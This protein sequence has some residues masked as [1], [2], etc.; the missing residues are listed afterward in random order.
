[1]SSEQTLNAFLDELA[2][3]APAPGGG[4]AAAAAGAMGAALV[5]MVCNLTIG[6]EK[7]AAVENQMKAI[8]A[9]AGELQAQLT[10]MMQKDV[11]AFDQVM[12]A[13]RLPKDSHEEKVARS[14]AI[15]A[16]AK[17][18]TLAPLSTARGCAELIVLSKS[19]AEM[20]NPNV[21]SDAGVAVLC[22]QTGLKGAALNVFINLTMIKDQAFVAQHKTDLDEILAGHDALANEIYELV[23]NKLEK[24]A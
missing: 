19:V 15:Q 13:Y 24:K 20:G 16:G 14:A 3:S 6:K 17:T 23:K 1:M 10:T 18:A 12:T 9:R 4:S 7:F 22:A 2:S 21:A 11:E 5:S 8:L